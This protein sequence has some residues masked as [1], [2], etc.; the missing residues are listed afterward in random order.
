MTAGLK[1]C[2]RLI[3]FAAPSRPLLTI[4]N[5]LIPKN[6]QTS[7]TKI[8]IGCIRNIITGS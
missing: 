1:K 3:L 4:Y 2:F 8:C 5:T 6:N 7:A